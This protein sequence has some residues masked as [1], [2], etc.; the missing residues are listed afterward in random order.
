MGKKRAKPKLSEVVTENVNNAAD[1]KLDMEALDVMLQKINPELKAYN[2]NLLE[3]DFLVHLSKENQPKHLC[4]LRFRCFIWVKEKQ[5]NR[6]LDDYEKAKLF[7]AF[8]SG[9][10]SSIWD[11][12]NNERPK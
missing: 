11:T 2:P 9:F 4:Q 6:K 5:E 8:E 1:A 3:L 10:F 12:K 7:P